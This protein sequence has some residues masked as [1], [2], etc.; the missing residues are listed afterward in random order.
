MTDPAVHG[1][2]SPREVMRR[3]DLRPRKRLGQHFLSDPALLR[4]ITAACELTTSD[5]VLEIG[6][7]TGALTAYL[8]HPGR[9]VI[10]V[11]VDPLLAA[12]LP[13]V[14]GH[15]PGLEVVTA[16]VRRVDLASLLARAPR[17]AA[18]RAWVVAGNVPYLITTHIVT[19]LL[20]ARALI[21][22]AVLLVQREYAARLAASPGSSDYGALTLFVR[23]HAIVQTLFAVGRGSFYP[24]P[25]V[26]SAVIRLVPRRAP[27]VP[28]R[29][30]QMLRA[31][32]RAA[33]GM[34]RK[35]LG[36]ALAPLANE[37]GARAQDVCRAADVD[38][39]RRGETLDLRE[40][41][42][43][44]DA[45]SAV[46][47]AHDATPRSDEARRRTARDALRRGDEV[48]GATSHRDEPPREGE[49]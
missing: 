36:N 18:E 20:D 42:A 31:V 23:Q 38:P 4:R 17:V 48:R 30:E 28:V 3:L 11:E 7:G 16:D 43:L 15:P 32:I 21:S 46:D 29:D 24:P 26:D 14:L 25:E 39:R 49:T 12:A 5:D 8:V 47:E 19:M 10:A 45:L 40:F 41:A 44:A 33:F 37:R 34:R 1:V 13:D 35:M 27:A 22:R 9:R 6:A 2:P